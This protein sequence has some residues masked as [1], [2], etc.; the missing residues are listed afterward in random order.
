MNADLLIPVAVAGFVLVACAMVFM[1]RGSRPSVN[2]TVM[3]R[4]SRPDLA[5]E[6]V[7]PR[8]ILAA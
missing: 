7:S 6:A 4:M 8:P 2:R 1:R 3:R 5:L